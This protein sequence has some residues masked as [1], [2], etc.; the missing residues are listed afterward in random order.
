[1]RKGVPISI[2]VGVILSLCFCCFPGGEARALRV[3][4][5]PCDSLQ[6]YNT[7]EALQACLTAQPYSSALK[8][9]TGTE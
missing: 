7:F 2:W 4:V 3:A 8:Q 9:A 1:M 5:S 6:R